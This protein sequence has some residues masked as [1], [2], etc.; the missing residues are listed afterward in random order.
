VPTPSS[1]AVGDLAI[2]LVQPGR[3][4]E[5]KDLLLVIE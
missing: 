4:V 2:F 1:K 3:H 5:A